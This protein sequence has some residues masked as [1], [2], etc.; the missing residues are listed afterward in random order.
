MLCM[1]FILVVP[2]V[3]SQGVSPQVTGIHLLLVALLTSGSSPE[4]STRYFSLDQRFGPSNLTNGG[5]KK[6]HKQ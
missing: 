6:V 1:S 3:E 2:L 4:S 5:A